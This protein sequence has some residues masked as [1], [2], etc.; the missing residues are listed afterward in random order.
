MICTTYFQAELDKLNTASPIKS[1]RI[2][3]RLFYFNSKNIPST[4][5]WRPKGFAEDSISDEP[6]SGIEG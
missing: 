2:F 5:L 3:L 6:D 4:D 1:R